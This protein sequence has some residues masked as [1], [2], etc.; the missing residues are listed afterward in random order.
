MAA[1]LFGSGS[2]FPPAVLS[3]W[4]SASSLALCVAPN[5]P[6]APPSLVDQPP[7]TWVLRTPLASGS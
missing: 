2:L 1:A 6:A 7:N 5:V 4:L 3:I